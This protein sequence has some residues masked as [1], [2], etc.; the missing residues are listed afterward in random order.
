MYLAYLWTSSQLARHKIETIFTMTF[1]FTKFFKYTWLM[2]LRH[3]TTSF[4]TDQTVTVTTKAKPWVLT[5]IW[6]S[7]I[8][9]NLFKTHTSILQAL[10][11]FP[12]L[13]EL[14]LSQHICRNFYRSL[15]LIVLVLHFRNYHFLYIVNNC[16]NKSRRVFL[17][18]DKYVL[19][20]N[21]QKQQPETFCKKRSS[22]K[23]H[24]IHRKTT[25]PEFI[26]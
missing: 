7:L 14:R 23:F 6:L 19:L 11:I 10:V 21:N 1:L 26:F 16:E 15:Q 22:W 18:F 4:L 3:F 25:V 5:F 20:V 24:K 9:G 13:I 2:L 12:A 17:C 8:N